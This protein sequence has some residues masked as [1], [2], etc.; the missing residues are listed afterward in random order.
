V[1]NA[2][3]LIALS[4]LKEFCWGRALPSNCCLSRCDSGLSLLML[5]IDHFKQVNKTNEAV[6]KL[7]QISSF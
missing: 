7:A 2:K 6:E 1:N 3:T 4:L 5:D